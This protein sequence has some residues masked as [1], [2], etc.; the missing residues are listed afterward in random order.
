MPK[1]SKKKI[2]AITGSMG[3]GKSMVSS[4]L[5]ENF[6]VLDVDQVNRQLIEKGNKGY[7]QLVKEM[8]I[9]LDEKKNIDKS[10]FAQ[11][12]FTDKTYKQKVESILHPLIVESM[13]EWIEQ[14]ENTLV[15]VEVPLLFESHME[16]LFDEIWCVVCD[17]EVA[18]QRLETKRHITRENAKARLACQ[19]SPVIKMQQSDVVLYNNGTLEQL[20]EQVKLHLERSLA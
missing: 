18:L 12:M 4:M 9:P 10:A 7:R 16:D 14:Q 13:Q 20:R 5:K 15:F 11:C 19:Y 1:M 8:K 2:I 17:E 3:S 6:P